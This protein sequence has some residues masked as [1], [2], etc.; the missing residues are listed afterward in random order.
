MYVYTTEEK[1]QIVK[2]YYAGSTIRE[3]VGR[4]AFAFENRP[5]PTEHT[6]LNIIHKFE[7]CG[8]VTN[9]RKC[10]HL[11]DEEP[12]NRYINEERQN[13]E[14]MIC[15]VAEANVSTAKQIS[16]ESGVKQRTVQ[17]VLKR[18]GYK[19]RK[20]RSTQEIFAHDEN[21]R[22]EFCEII[23]Y[24]VEENENFINN[25]LFTDE[26]SFSLH[27]SHNSQVT[28]YWSKENRHLNSQ[29]HTQYPQKLN[30]WAGILNN[31]VVGPFF[32]DG[33]LNAYKYLNMLNNDIIPTVHNAN[34]NFE[35]IWYQQDGCP[36]HN[37]RNV[38][39]FLR[40]TFHDRIISRDCTISWPPRSP[41]LSPNDFFLWGYIK[42][43][44]YDTPHEGIGNLN[45]LRAKIINAFHTITPEMLANVRQE[46]YYRLAYCQ[47]QH[48]GLFEH[49]I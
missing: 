33:M 13:R 18:H 40:N 34:V 1:I 48:G 27:G 23:M 42:Q 38:K 43:K 31:T 9:C 44:V 39:E 19:W 20:F 49:L 11:Q 12:R 47:E 2:W 46:F 45:D 6:V 8:C 37:A 4:F 22:L 15:A 16:D 28:G 25:I 7:A 41:D 24:K 30:V 3:I 32:I 17:R 5:I 10:L 14:T 21:N 36:A 29:T 35:D 26:T